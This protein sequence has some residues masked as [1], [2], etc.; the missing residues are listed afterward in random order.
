MNSQPVLYLMT[1]L[2]FGTTLLSLG[3]ALGFWMGR[4]TAAPMSPG[5]STPS[6]DPQQF[7]SLVR[8]MANWTSDVAGDVSKYQSQLTTLTEQ[9]QK[10][11]IDGNKE[12][13]QRVL[14]QILSANRA[15][16]SRLEAAEQKLESQTN[17]LE[18]F[19]TEARTDPLTGLSNRRVFD[20]RMDEQFAKFKSTQQPFTLALLDIDHFKKIND[21][22][23]HASG[24]EVLREV[25]ARLREISDQCNLV[26]RYGGEEF[27]VVFN[28]P[29]A[30]SVKVMDQLRAN[31]AAKPVLVDGKS[32]R[33]TFSCG[34]AQLQ[35]GDRVGNLFR[36]TDEALYCAKQNGRNMVV[37]RSGNGYESN[38]KPLQLKLNNALASVAVG[39]AAGTSD[40]APNIAPSGNAT[41][42]A[43][44]TIDELEV[45]ILK[46]LDH[47]V[48]EEA[49]RLD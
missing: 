28:A 48:N 18:G 39:Q 2:L 21:T 10:N 46:R 44:P 3:V 29:L 45:R 43:S 13:F 4:R 14:D 34:V 15:L 36:Y 38:G 11:S 32:I 40:N 7:L 5:S 37:T 23:G 8:S 1:G 6:M 17:Q 31:V 42:E 35:T 24:D 30:Q 16:Q 19:L 12:E 41:L 9:A 47:L 27:A 20:Q 26:A 22:H 49:K 33:V 25:G